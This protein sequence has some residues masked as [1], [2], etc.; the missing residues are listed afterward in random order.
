MIRKNLSLTEK[1]ILPL[2]SKK[3]WQLN[4]ECSAIAQAPD[5]THAQ[6]HLPNPDCE[7]RASTDS[8][9]PGDVV[10]VKLDRLCARCVTC[11]TSSN[12]STSAAP[13]SAP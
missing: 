9:K 8:D 10:V 11:S 2:R 12:E 4:Q 6:S 1:K 5:H 7:I 13:G 3:F